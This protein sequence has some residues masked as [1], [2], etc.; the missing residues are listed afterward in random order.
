MKKK[1]NIIEKINK[2]ESGQAFAELCVSLIPLLCVMLFMIYFAGISI[3]STEILLDAR[4]EAAENA[5]NGTNSSDRGSM[6]KS[7]TFGHDQE[8]SSTSMSYFQDDKASGSTSISSNTFLDEFNSNSLQFTTNQTTSTVYNASGFSQVSDQIFLDAADLTCGQARES[9]YS[10][11][12]STLNINS[13]G[14]LLT[15]NQRDKMDETFDFLLPGDSLINR[16]LKD[17]MPNW[18]VN[19]V[20]MPVQRSEDQTPSE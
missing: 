4:G 11:P 20:Y 18:Q 7:W 12:V 2:D 8:D 13:S 9:D 1:N 14:G 10:H 3:S 5:V 6:I 19:K 15:T 16:L 17:E